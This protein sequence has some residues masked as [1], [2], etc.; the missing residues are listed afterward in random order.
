MCSG[1]TGICGQQG[2]ICISVDD[3]NGNVLRL[4]QNANGKSMLSHYLISTII[5]IEDVFAV[6]LERH[7]CMSWFLI[8]FAF[9]NTYPYLSRFLSYSFLEIQKKSY[10]KSLYKKKHAC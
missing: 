10:K 4:V 7:S 2:C 5:K 1:A 8:S 9:G 3:W 6:T